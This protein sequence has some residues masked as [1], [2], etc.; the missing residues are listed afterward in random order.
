MKRLIPLLLLLVLLCGCGDEKDYLSVR[1]HVEQQSQITQAPETDASPVVGNRLEL[2]GAILSLI[3]NWKEQGKILIRNYDGDLEQNLSEAMDYATRQHP[4]GAY[5]V[6]Y[7]HSEILQEDGQ[8]YVQ[9][10]IVFRRSLSEINS[11]VL[12]DDNKA[13]FQK[14]Q[15]SLDHLNNALTLRVRRYQETDLAGE[16][17]DY[18]LDNP[19]TIPCVPDYSIKLYPESGDHRII[20]L[21]F[22]YPESREMMRSKLQ[23]IQTTFDSAANH[24]AMGR[25]PYEKAKLLYQYLIRRSCTLTDT[26]P[27]MPVYS[28]ISDNVAHDLS[29]A[30]FYNR[31]CKDAGLSA[32]I[33]KGSKN[34]RDYY[35]NLLQLG[36]DVFHVDLRRCLE[37]GEREMPLLYDEDLLREGYVWDQSI[38]AAAPKPQEEVTTTVPE[39]ISTNPSET[40]PTESGPTET[41]PPTQEVTEIEETEPSTETES[42]GGTEVSTE[43]ELPSE[44]ESSSTEG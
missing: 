5:A 44:T 9:I 17:A 40:P 38:Y 16:I 19:R 18:C 39:E 8:Q 29:L 10:S 6:D 41:E 32:T 25:T 3:D 13:A 4:T 12:V 30:V 21:R 24:G 37:L 27:V 22:N 34:D 1:P 11:I 31:L 35:W 42:S 23:E 2:R 28:L 7:A 43:T 33:I 36:E 20:E 14:I 15:E 26:K